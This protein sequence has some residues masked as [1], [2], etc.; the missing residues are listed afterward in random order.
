MAFL[1]SL[2]RLTTLARNYNLVL[3]QWVLLHC[4]HWMGGKGYLDLV[5][6]EVYRSNLETTT[7]FWGSFWQQNVHIFKDFSQ[8]LEPCFTII[9]CSM[10]NTRTVWKFW[11]NRPMFGYIFVANGKRVNGF[12]VKK[13]PIRAARPHVLIWESPQHRTKP[14]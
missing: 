6:T 7:H 13:W 10:V 9:R 8:N 4:S 12:L 11:K 1:E 3:I 2:Q 5:W 14:V